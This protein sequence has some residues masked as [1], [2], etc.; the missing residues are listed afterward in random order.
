MKTIRQVLILIALL[1]STTAFSQIQLSFI[2]FKNWIQQKAPTGYTATD[3][4]DET[5]SYSAMLVKG[6]ILVTV[7][8]NDI[9]QLDDDL[10]PLRSTSK[11]IE[12]ERN[13]IR[14]LYAEGSVRMLYLQLPSINATLILGTANANLKKADLE[15]I[16]DALGASNIQP[17]KSASNSW[18]SEIP[19]QLRLETDLISIQKMEASTEGYEYEYHV[20]VKNDKNLIPAINKVT[21]VC[22]GDLSMTKFKNFTLICADTDSMDGLQSIKAGETVVFIY[23]KSIK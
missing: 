10:R 14:S 2:E 22:G 20:K 19:S 16:S 13:G 4:N 9:Q 11:P 17:V 6:D 7:S 18:P 23:Y 1:F 3:F 15:K 8:L 12:Y 5:G 21:N